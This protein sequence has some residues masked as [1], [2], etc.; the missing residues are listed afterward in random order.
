MMK[1]GFLAQLGVVRCPHTAVKDKDWRK[2]SVLNTY[3]TNG[4]NYELM[5]DGVV[6]QT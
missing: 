6:V 4:K 2:S 3:T 5:L 1:L